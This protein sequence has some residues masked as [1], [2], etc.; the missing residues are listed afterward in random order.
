MKDIF[1]IE[2]NLAPSTLILLME[3]EAP[4]TVLGHLLALVDQHTDVLWV[5]KG[6]RLAPDDGKGGRDVG[7]P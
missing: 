3:A 6:L 4:L 2:T 1:L 7:H 5:V